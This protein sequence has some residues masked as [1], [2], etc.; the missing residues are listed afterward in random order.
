MPNN[1]KD[2]QAITCP[3]QITVS[4]LFNKFL[5]S[6]QLMQQF[7]QN[8]RLYL[9]VKIAVFPLPGYMELNI[10]AVPSAQ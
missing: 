7:K 5:Q 4:A 10:V 1:A 2:L 8:T 3:M 9:K 6:R